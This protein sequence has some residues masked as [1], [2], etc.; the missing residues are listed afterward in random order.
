MDVSKLMVKITRRL[1]EKQE[2]KI[3]RGGFPRLAETLPAASDF[4]T[5]NSL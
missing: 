4:E 2:L 3:H 5:N 1:R